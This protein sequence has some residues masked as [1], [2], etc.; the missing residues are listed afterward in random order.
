MF[1]IMLLV[2]VFLIGVCIGAIIIVCN[3]RRHIPIVGVFLAEPSS[4]KSTQNI[5]ATF[6]V[7]YEK[8]C[9]DKY[10]IMKVKSDFKE[11]P[12]PK[13]KECCNCEDCK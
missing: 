3:Y 12:L 11:Y 9:K 4:N 13:G 10:V 2:V 8:F 7:P 6:F 5:F 1:E